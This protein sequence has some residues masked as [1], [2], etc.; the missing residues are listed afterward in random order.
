MIRLEVKVS[1]NVGLS[2]TVFMRHVLAIMLL[3]ACTAGMLFSQECPKAV[4]ARI[5]SEAE[6]GHSKAQVSLGLELA[7]RYR[8]HG[9]D[10]S[11]AVKWFR[12]AA[13]PLTAR[14]VLSVAYNS[15]R[16]SGVVPARR[17]LGGP[18]DR[19][20]ESAPGERKAGRL[21]VY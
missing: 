4:Q 2:S 12:L 1:V 10:Y 20:R 14:L 21:S 8:S 3:V 13:A 17:G 9:R 16:E 11:Q 15:S 19:R 18:A 7:R 6:Q 5:R